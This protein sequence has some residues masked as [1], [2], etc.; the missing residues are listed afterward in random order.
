[1]ISFTLTTAVFLGSNA[2]AANSIDVP[3]QSLTSQGEDSQ[4]L[5]ASQDFSVKIPDGWIIEE[6][7]N[8]NTHALLNKIM[9]GSRLLAVLCPREGAVVGGEEKYSCE[10]SKQRVQ[11][12]RYPDLYHEPIVTSNLAANKSD[13]LSFLDYY[14]SKLEK[15]GYT[16]I[17][18]IQNTMTSINRIDIDANTI[19]AIVPAN[20]VEMTYNASNSNHTRGFFLLATTNDDT[21]NTEAVSGCILSYEDSA[22]TQPS[23]S[24]PEPI[25][26]IFESFQFVNH[27]TDDKRFIQDNNSQR[28]QNDPIVRN[29]GL[30][31]YLDEIISPPADHPANTNANVK[32]STSNHS[33]DNQNNTG[34]I[35]EQYNEHLLRI[36]QDNENQVISRITNQL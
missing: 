25:A 33:Y 1:M 7:D 24:P 2:C 8:T 18:V 32:N 14:I 12:Q 20:L 26:Q 35:E 22:T 34:R 17:N 16:D 36:V 3:N 21:S 15:L 27:A 4:F 19:T 11:V 31:Q 30:P 29:R 13:Q 9:Q 6:I 23:G 28:Y 10:E 5:S